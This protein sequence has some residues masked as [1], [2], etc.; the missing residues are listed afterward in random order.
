MY[1]DE[2][3]PDEKY[4]H[5]WGKELLGR[6]ASGEAERAAARKAVLHT[7]DLAEELRSLAAGRLLVE[8]LPGC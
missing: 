7:L 8:A 4:H 1:R 3:Q 6:L 5:D 2:I